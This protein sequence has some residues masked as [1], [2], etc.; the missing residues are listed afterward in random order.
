MAPEESEQPAPKG[1]ARLTLAIRMVVSLGLLAILVTKIDFNGAMPKDRHL[2]TLLFFA[3][4]VPPAMIGIVL[5]AWRWQRVLLAF[6]ATVPLR[7]LT[8]HYFAGQF[9]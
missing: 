4:A 8:G 3:P 6:D 1:R 5:S 9:V 7:A 2:S